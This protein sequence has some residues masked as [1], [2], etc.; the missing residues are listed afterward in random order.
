VSGGTDRDRGESGTLQHEVAPRF[1]EIS[2]MRIANMT[3]SQVVDRLFESLE[4]NRGGWLLT[5]TL[6]YARRFATDAA[7]RELFG[8]ADLM[9]ADGM[10][11]LWAAWIRGTPLP[12]R[13]AGSDL[14]WLI[15]ARAALEGR[16]LFL[17]GGSPG[18]A[19]G[20]RAQ[21]LERW[22]RLSIRYA[23]PLL[24]DAPSQ[25]EIRAIRDQLLEEAPDLIYVALGVPKQDRVIAA[26]R[27]D[28][29]GTWFVGVGVSLSFMAG[30]Q[31][32][33]PLWMQRSGL[34]WLHRL[35]HEPGRLGR[36][37]LL[38]DLPF[39]F[40]LLATSWRTRWVSRPVR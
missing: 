38:D 15:A 10:P 27:A 39:A 2:G 1:I 6:D 40:W 20:A 22:P 21:L 18:A 7:A 36:R 31:R 30:S 11:L 3:R 13:V 14:V 23:A 5:A 4:Q 33:A 37:Y 19:E 29:S 26:L 12:D 35:A 8:G 34:E 28:F 24:S 16:S 32:R 25:E 17:L 9:V